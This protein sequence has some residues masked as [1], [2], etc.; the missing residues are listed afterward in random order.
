[1]TEM[2]FSVVV[3]GTSLVAFLQRL[4]VFVDCLVMKQLSSQLV[5]NEQLE[6]YFEGGGV[7]VRLPIVLY[8]VQRHVWTL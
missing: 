2:V 1:M 4:G 3:E 6:R 7:A 5:L 8:V